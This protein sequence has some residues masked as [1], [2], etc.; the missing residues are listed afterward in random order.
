MRASFCSSKAG[1]QISPASFGG[2]GRE[3]DRILLCISGWL[4]HSSVYKAL[5]SMSKGRR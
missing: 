2:L 4:K 1:R 5:R 3:W